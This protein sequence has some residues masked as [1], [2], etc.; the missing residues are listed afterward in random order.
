MLF[1]SGA[2]GLVVATAAAEQFVQRASCIA[3]VTATSGIAFGGRRFRQILPA[4]ALGIGMVPLPYVVYY[5]L[6]FPLQLLS[7]QWAAGGV[8]LLGFEVTRDGNVFT[9][10]GHALEVVRAC[11]GIRSIMALVTVAAAGA[12]WIR[13][14]L[15]RAAILTLAAIPAAVAGNVLRLVVTALLVARFGP[16]L[17]EGTVHE[18]VG[19]VCFGVSLAMLAGV[20]ALLRRGAHASDEPL[21]PRGA[22]SWSLRLRQALH[23]AR[24]V[25]ARHAWIA[26]AILSASGAYAVFLHQH[27]VVPREPVR[28]E[29]SIPLEIGDLYAVDLG[30]DER[31][32]EQVAPT[33]FVFRSYAAP[34]GADFALYAGYY[35]NLRQG[36]QIHSPLHCYPGAGWK[37]VDTEPLAVRDLRGEATSMQRL[38]VERRG[39]RDVVVYWYE[40]RAGR[41]TNDYALKFAQLR[42][43]L[44]RQPQDAAFVRWST[45]ILD[46]E[47]TEDA[48]RRLLGVVGRSL[49]AIESALPFRG[50]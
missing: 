3:L 12:V 33:S 2:I 42:T 31:V 13:R 45:P 36:T 26:V 16:H 11:S 7:T 30:M 49:P 6:T 44:L 39:R 10:D 4:F 21:A 15:G 37:I 28:L 18:I 47:T 9:V 22:G 50:A 17:A 34:D 35:R 29:D 24:P 40:T 20:V 25:S 19:V 43:S 27:R 8:A 38:L 46:G 5:A 48:T 41:T 14:G 32:L 1:A 23:R